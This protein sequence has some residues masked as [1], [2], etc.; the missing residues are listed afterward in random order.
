[1][2]EQVELV[3]KE[4]E[5]RREQARMVRQRSVLLRWKADSTA[6]AY[7]KPGSNSPSR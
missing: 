1:M 4:S 2:L 3:L 7:Y 5:F 6:S